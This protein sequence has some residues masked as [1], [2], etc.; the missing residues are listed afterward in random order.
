MSRL[1]RPSHWPIARVAQK[2]GVE[3]APGCEA[4]LA[5]WLD[6]LVE[7]NA[8]LD[9]TAARTVNELVDLMLADALVVAALVPTGA[10]LVDVGTGA[11]APGLALAVLRPDLKITLVEPLTKRISFLRTVLGKL[12]RPDIVL[13]RARVED[14]ETRFDVAISRATLPPLSWLSAGL[15]LADQV[16]VLLAKDDAPSYEGAE[17]V[18]DLTYQ[19]PLTEATRRMVGYRNTAE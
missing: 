15:G 8:R 14:L 17:I 16:W 19:W 4:Q 9:L 18:Q 12:G 3:L 1:V 11:G 10:S 13:V 5:T 7:W 6:T 2:L